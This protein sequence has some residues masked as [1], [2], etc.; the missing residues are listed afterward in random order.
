METQLGIITSPVA[1]EWGNGTYIAIT[2]QGPE[3]SLGLEKIT[4]SNS[5]H[6]VRGTFVEETS[7]S[8]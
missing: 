7:S 5:F 1:K 4:E 2:E 8:D 6:I 3:V